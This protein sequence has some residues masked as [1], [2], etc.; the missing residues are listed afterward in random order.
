MRPPIGTTSTLVLTALTLGCASTNDAAT[1]A[2]LM[3]ASFT[4]SPGTGTY[5]TV[6]RRVIDQEMQGT[7][8]QTRTNLS[9]R[10]S[11]EVSET[12]GQLACQ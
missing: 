3:P 4:F 6:S 10:L 12:G 9:Y 5:L 8:Q 7:R 11:S 2:P 1:V